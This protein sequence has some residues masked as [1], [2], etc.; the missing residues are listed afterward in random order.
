MILTGLRRLTTIFLSIVFLLFPSAQLGLSG[1]A[2]GQSSNAQDSSAQEDFSQH[3]TNL[4]TQAVVAPNGVLVKWRTDFEIDILGFEIYRVENGQRTLLNQKLIPGSVFVVGAGIP[5]RAGYSYQWFDRGGSARSFYSIETIAL[6]GSRKLS[7]G[8]AAVALG[9]LPASQQAAVIESIRSSGATEGATSALVKEYPAGLASD[10]PQTANGS[11]ENQWAVA[12]QTALKIFIKT[13]GWYRVTQSQMAAAGFNPNVDIRNLSLFGD[14]QEIA[15]LTSKDVGQLNSGDY[16]EF[17]GQGLDTPSADTRVYYLIAGTAL[18]K[19]VTGEVRLDSPPDPPASPPTDMPP[20]TYTAPRLNFPSSTWLQSLLNLIG[21]DTASPRSAEKTETVVPAAAATP[22]RREAS[23]E[24]PEIQPGRPETLASPSESSAAAEPA[25]KIAEVAP[26]AT[27]ADPLARKNAQLDQ[28]QVSKGRRRSNRKQRRRPKSRKS[29]SLLHNHAVAAAA[30]SSLSFNYTVQLK[31]RLFYIYTILNGEAEN[32]F[33]DVIYTHTAGQPPVDASFITETLPVHNVQLAADRPARLEV[34]LQGIVF[35]NHQINVLVNGVLVGSVNFSGLTHGVQTFD[36]PVSQLLEGNNTF[37]LQ[38][39]LPPGTTSDTVDLDYIKLTYPHSYTADNDSLRFSLRSTQTLNVDGFSTSGLRLLDISDPTSVRMSRPIVGPSGG[40]YAVTV[41][42]GSPGKAGRLM[43]A[44][45]EGQFLQPSGFSLNQP[46]TLNLGGSAT[47][48]NGG[49]FLIVAYK[50]FIPSLAPLIAQRQ[51]QGLTVVVADVEDV[52]DEFSYGTHNAL[53]IRNLVARASA[54]WT[55][56]PAYLLLFGDASSDPRNYEGWG[57]QDFVPS[58]MI[59]TFYGEVCADDLLADLNDDGI[60]EL[61]VG[62]LPVQSVSQAN[63][64][65]S[66]IVNFSVTNAPK[67]TMLVADTQGTYYWNFEAASDEVQAIMP[68]TMTVQKVYRR[69]EANDTAAHTNIVNKF[70][71]GLSL[72]NYSGHGNATA[73]TGGGIFQSDDAIA[74]T[75]GNRLPFV[76]VMDCLN[77]RFDFPNSG[78]AQFNGI[79]EALLKAPAGGAVAAW[80]SSGLTLPNGQHDMSMA[81]YQSVYG[82]GAQ[83]I[84]LGDAVRQSKSATLD[85]DVRRSWIFFGDPTLKVW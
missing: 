56:K 25:S 36:V 80:A 34:A 33:G 32:Y 53:A 70:N 37:K 13:D 21:P 19:R 71:L 18:G 51:S 59:D 82:S 84:R 49:D 50:D 55:K 20:P 46:S 78:G 52:Y 42:S 67:T 8:I 39:V 68:V 26:A 69:L 16:I 85:L 79:A 54:N 7:D 1:G 77:G 6:N 17:Y 43:Y 76:V 30:A 75:N 66:K 10:E 35:P 31:S 58:K 74:L 64:V 27:K 61:A 15:I 38:Q 24:F 4:S 63:L 29:H 44:L 83:P 9:K 73:W 2:R 11:L 28:Q 12:A 45:P 22:N 23:S 48:T 60:P 65:V 5:L 14:G 40:G 3:Q 41:P 57:F 81:M 47:S 72:V 62:R